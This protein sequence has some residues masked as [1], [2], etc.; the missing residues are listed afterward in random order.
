MALRAPARCDHFV[1]TARRC[2]VGDR[3]EGSLEEGLTLDRLL[4]LTKLLGL[5]I[6]VQDRGEKPAS[7]ADW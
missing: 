6:V 4:V 7:G 1:S 2:G 3:I 5:E